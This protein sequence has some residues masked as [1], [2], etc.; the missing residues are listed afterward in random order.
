[1]I[2]H[3][4]N[5]LAV[6]STNFRGDNL[7]FTPPFL[8][9]FPPPISLS[10]SLFLY[11]CLSLPHFFSSTSPLYVFHQVSSLKSKLKKQ[12]TATGSGVARAF[13]RAQA[14]LFGS[15]RDAL[16]YRPVRIHC[17]KSL[18]I[19]LYNSITVSYYSLIFLKSFMIGYM[20]VYHQTQNVIHAS[21]IT[22]KHTFFLH[23]KV[24]IEYKG[25]RLYFHSQA[26]I[27]TDMNIIYLLFRM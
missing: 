26:E 7:T 13:M 15:Y 6:S 19:I 22:K 12:S 17:H 10:L 3:T 4:Q 23:F 9:F 2:L 16:R 27:F 5:G 20:L 24:N 1:M 11:F 25:K 8:P 21:Q 18:P 14:A